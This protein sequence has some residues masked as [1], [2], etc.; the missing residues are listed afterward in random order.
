MYVCI[1]VYVYIHIHTHLFG[2]RIKSQ[3]NN[4]ELKSYRVRAL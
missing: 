3:R 1:Y 2:I 4:Q